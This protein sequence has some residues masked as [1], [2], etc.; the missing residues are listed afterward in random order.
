MKLLLL[1]PVLPFF[2]YA[3]P[4]AFSAG[5]LDSKN[6]YGLTPR[7]KKI[8]ENKKKVRNLTNKFGNVDAKV[9][10]TMTSIEGMRDEIE[11]NSIQTNAI[12]KKIARIENILGIGKAGAND[13]NSTNQNQSIITVANKVATLDS[14][15]KFSIA[16]R[17]DKIEKYIQESGMLQKENYTKINGSLRKIAKLTDAK[18]SRREVKRIIRTEIK[19][20]LDAMF[21]KK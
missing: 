6:P 13:F 11:R 1:I 2:L 3:E 12:D 19:R 7:E 9:R 16:Q 10:D 21:K 14:N 18:P 17:L 8:L 5:N 15:K 4:S 20:Y